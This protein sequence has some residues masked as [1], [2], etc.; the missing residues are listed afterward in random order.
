AERRVLHLQEALPERRFLYGADLSGDAFPDGL[1]HRAVR[2]RAHRR[3]ALAVGRDAVGQGA[4]DRAS[5]ADLYG[6]CGAA[7]QADPR[8]Q[9]QDYEVVQ[10]GDV[11][12]GILDPMQDADE[13]CGMRG[14]VMRGENSH[15]T[16]WPRIPHSTVDLMSSRYPHSSSGACIREHRVESPHSLLLPH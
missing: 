4:E 14:R 2:H 5:A 12:C 6:A 16:T 1:L 7:I 13:E 10:R 11:G 15:F 3:L 9:A 8:L